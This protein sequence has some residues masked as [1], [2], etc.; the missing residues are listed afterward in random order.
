MTIKNTEKKKHK[1]NIVS[2]HE[3]PNDWYTDKHAIERNVCRL[4]SSS[5]DKNSCV[6]QHLMKT[7]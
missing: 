5:N 7:Q 6:H 1:N 4:F 2:F 3:Q